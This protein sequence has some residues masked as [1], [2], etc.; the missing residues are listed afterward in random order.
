MI[1]VVLPQVARELQLT[2]RQV[3]ATAG[4][5]DGGATVPF[6]ARYR[7]EVTASL[8]EV[9]IAN[10]RDR[11]LQLR[12]LAD[13]RET[14]L[15]S[16]GERDLLTEELRKDVLSAEAMMVLEDIYLPYRPK[17]RTRATIAREKGLELLALELWGQ[18][19]FDVNLT[20]AEYVNSEL[21]VENVEDALGGARDIIA[22]WVSE[23]TTAR[24]RIRSLFWSQGIFSSR[25]VS[26]KDSAAAKYR[27]YFQWE[28]QVTDLPS[29]RVL[30]ML[31]GEREGLLSIHIAPPIGKAIAI[32]EG[33]LITRET[34]ASQQVRLAIQDG[35]S[36]CWK[37]LWRR[38]SAKKP[39]FAPSTLP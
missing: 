1:D 20:A 8:D 25:V 36:G 32:L 10:I 30:A 21:G 24:G 35:Y 17:R 39:E 23:D 9:A 31:R 34:E 12:E 3:Q 5:L 18:Q 15:A 37:H 7:K 29:H 38:K 6:I 4:L 13:R 19:D 22:E 11:L 2:Q 16:L 14:I 26:G 33:I 28:E 27:D